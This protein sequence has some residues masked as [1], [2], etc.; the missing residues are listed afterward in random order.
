MLIRYYRAEDFAITISYSMR[1]FASCSHGASLGGVNFLL[2]K[3]FEA[4][5]T[6]RDASPIVHPHRVPLSF[7]QKFGICA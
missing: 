2:F 4:F 7:G 5:D 6:T 3:M 1:V